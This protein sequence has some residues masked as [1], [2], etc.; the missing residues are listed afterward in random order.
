[1]NHEDCSLCRA[2]PS[3]CFE[4]LAGGNHVT[5]PLPEAIKRFTLLG[6]TRTNTMYEVLRCP[7]CG[8]YYKSVYDRFNVANG[9]EEQSTTITRLSAEESIVAL[10]E[11]D[12]WRV[13]LAEIAQKK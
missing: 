11:L 6:E 13:R 7:E 12:A 1:M 4:E 2:V 3:A 9:P 5:D 8:T 10:A